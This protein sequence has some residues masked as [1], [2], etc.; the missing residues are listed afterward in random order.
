MSGPTFLGSEGAPRGKR[1]RYVPGRGA[2]VERVF[3]GNERYIYGIFNSLS[4]DQYAEIDDSESPLFRLIV[5]TADIDEV[6]GTTAPVQ[7]VWELLGNTLERDLKE[8]PNFRD[9]PPKVMANIQ[10]L[11]DEPS[12]PVSVSPAWDDA[13]QAFYELARH[14][15]V[16]YADSQWVLRRTMIAGTRYQTEYS[17]DGVKKLWTTAQLKTKEGLPATLFWDVSKLTAPVE[18]ADHLW[19]W[20]KMGPVITQTVAGRWQIS[21]EFWLENWS[22]WIYDVQPD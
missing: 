3:T 14:G 2:S 15:T 22:T 9:I 12:T 1:I 20:L 19:S 17:L 8:H 18:L 21:Q 4:A 13:A 7:T 10:D 16:K 5:R 11:I 6:P